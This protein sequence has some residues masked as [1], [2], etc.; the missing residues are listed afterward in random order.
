METYW[1]EVDA[2]TAEEKDESWENKMK[3]MEKKYKPSEWE[4][5][6]GSSNGGYHYLGAAK[7]MTPIGKAF[8][9]ALLPMQK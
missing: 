5:L 2:K 6:K 4:K 1:P 9:V 3:H 7:I 8:A